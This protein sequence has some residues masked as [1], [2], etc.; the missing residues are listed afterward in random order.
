MVA[1]QRQNDQRSDDQTR[2]GDDGE[3]PVDHLPGPTPYGL[4]SNWTLSGSFG[5]GGDI[6]ITCVYVVTEYVDQYIDGC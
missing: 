6:E 3:G 2:G 1:C 5:G 4:T